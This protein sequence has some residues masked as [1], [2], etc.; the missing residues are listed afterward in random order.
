VD[1]K[2]VAEDLVVRDRQDQERKIAPL[3]ASED[4]TIVDSTKMSVAEVVEKMI[5]IIRGA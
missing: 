4:A 1:Y 2:K 3:K 5:S